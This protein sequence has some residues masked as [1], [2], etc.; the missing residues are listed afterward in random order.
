MAS[1]R[2]PR[3]ELNKQ[4]DFL[5]IQEFAYVP[6]GV[7]F[8]N[9]ND[10]RTSKKPVSVNIPDLNDPSKNTK[11]NVKVGGIASVNQ[12]GRKNRSTKTGGD[13]IILPIPSNIQ[14]SN[15]VKYTEGNLD[16]LTASV[17]GV[18]NSAVQNNTSNIS[19]VIS[20]L[21]KNATDIG[22][23]PGTKEYF[24]RS[25]AA[26]AAN[27]PFGGNLTASQLLARTTGNILN[28]NLE[29]LFDGVTLRTFKFSFKFTPR[30]EPEAKDVKNIIRS[31]KKNMH[32]NFG[33]TGFNKR[34][35]SNIANLYLSTP[36]VYQLRYMRGDQPHPFLNKFKQCALTDM[37]VNYTGDG[38]YATYGDANATPISMVM[39]LSFKELEPIYAGDYREQGADGYDEDLHGGVGY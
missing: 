13:T 14:D 33:T 1:Y 30:N 31:F 27:I 21:L 34:E 24:L 9:L 29:L 8:T 18:V 6:S 35:S 36:R 15:S 12:I 28:P 32:P 38:T 23:D 3:A 10:I 11:T 25:L 17:L 39:D 22:L 16:G 5:H 7:K 37:S 20:N 2:Y 4:D 19:E 26:Q